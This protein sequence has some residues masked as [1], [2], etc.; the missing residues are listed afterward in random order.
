MKRPSGWR[1][2]TLRGACFLGLGAMIASALW[3]CGGGGRDVELTAHT[4]AHTPAPPD[5]GLT[6][7]LDSYRHTYARVAEVQ[8]SAVHWDQRVTIFISSAADTYQRNHAQFL[9][10]KEDPLLIPAFIHY[11]AGTVLVKEQRSPLATDQRDPGSWCVML[12]DA[13]RSDG[14]WRYVEIDRQRGV[15]LD[16]YANSPAVQERCATCHAEAKASDYVFSS[17]FDARLAGSNPH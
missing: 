16:G 3:S 13:A 12:K 5:A 11:P 2:P 9:A 8:L 17:Y 14:A 4:L 10:L 15:V 6:A 7:V 1:V